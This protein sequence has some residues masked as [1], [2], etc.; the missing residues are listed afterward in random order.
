MACCGAFPFF[1]CTSR[2]LAWLGGRRSMQPLGSS[3][4]SRVVCARHDSPGRWRATALR[5]GPVEFRSDSRPAARRFS[6]SMLSCSV[7][8]TRSMHEE[9]RR[10]RVGSAP[11]GTAVLSRPFSHVDR[12]HA[13]LAQSARAVGE[14]SWLDARPTS[15]RACFAPSGS[16]PPSG[17]SRL[18]CPFRPRLFLVSGSRRLP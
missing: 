15:D 3:G 14:S 1:F 12:R 13:A 10:S 6:A 4:T 2:F 17:L 18:P 11:S 5:P 9:A 7:S 8:R 16:P